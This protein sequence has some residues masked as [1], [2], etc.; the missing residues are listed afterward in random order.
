MRDDSVGDADDGVSKGCVTAMLG[1]HFARC[2]LVFQ[3]G[4]IAVVDDVCAGALR[5]FQADR[6]RHLRTVRQPLLAS[7]CSD[8][9]RLLK[10]IRRTDPSK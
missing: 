1:T 6:G 2:S 10:V 5:S 9:P 4:F 3:P 8:E 7:Y